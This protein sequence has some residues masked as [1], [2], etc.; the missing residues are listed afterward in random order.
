MR[1]VPILD[2]K[3]FAPSRSLQ[4]RH[5]GRKAGI[6]D[7]SSQDIEVTSDYPYRSKVKT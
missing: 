7:P 5:I 6:L 4:L 2:F 1:A 3:V